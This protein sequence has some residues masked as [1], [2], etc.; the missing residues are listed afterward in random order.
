[1]FERETSNVYYRIGK[2]KEYTRLPNKWKFLLIK[3]RD[4]KSIGQVFERETTRFLFDESS[5]GL[6]FS[7]FF[8][9]DA[10]SI[11]QANTSSTC[12]HI[13]V[14]HWSM[15]SKTECVEKISHVD[16]FFVFL[17]LFDKK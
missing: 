10:L 9:M 7:F 14:C 6:S 16:V 1:M 17:P 5:G 13:R 3:V 12:R 4:L 11:K 2:G 8:L 15:Q